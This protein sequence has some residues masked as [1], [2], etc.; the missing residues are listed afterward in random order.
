MKPHFDL[1][2]L[3]IHVSENSNASTQKLHLLVHLPAI[4]EDF[5]RFGQLNYALLNEQSTKDADQYFE[6]HATTG[7]VLLKKALDRET[8]EKFDLAIQVKDGGDL[9][10]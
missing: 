8:H 5:G 2:N 9:V 7:S 4:D 3:T 10:D 6:V 1:T